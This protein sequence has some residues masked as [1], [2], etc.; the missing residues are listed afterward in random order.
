[1]K[2]LLVDDDQLVLNGLRRALFCSDIQ[3]LTAN[4]GKQALD[5]L[6]HEECDLI[7]SDMMMPNMNG[8]ELLEIVSKKYPWIIRASLSGHA[9]PMITVKGGFYAHQAF[10]KPCDT[11]VLKDEIGRI[12]VMLDQFPDR[13]IQNAIGTI[14]S[15]PVAP[16]IY[17]KVKEMLASNSASLT[18][19]AGVISEDPA[20]S[21]KMIQMANNAIFRGKSEVKNVE[22]AVSRLGSQIVLNV[23]A[24][25]ELYVCQQDKPSK[26]LE[27]LWKQSLKVALV[28]SKLVPEAQ[29]LDAMSIGILHQ[30]GEF[31]RTM[32]LP[33]LM[34]T[35][36]H[37]SEKDGDK[38]YLEKY[39]FHTKSEQLGAYLLHLWGFPLQVIESILDQNDYD[40]I[41]AQPYSLVTAL[42]VAK[43]VVGKEQIPQAMLEQF[44]L[45][46][47]LA[48]IG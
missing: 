10:M 21:A 7:I 8:S 28:M 23:I 41:M 5:I 46:Q 26:A 29:R 48:V 9:D 34:K 47:P 30:V 32:I 24:M 2:I 27:T 44:D 14:T 17:F 3:V 22:A 40:K 37:C 11:A 31:V 12:G 13:L 35:Y 39:L 25:L 20:I 1:M 45:Q 15:L 18:D 33:D 36:L 6:S 19:I 43:R 4:G 38:S 16:K 42:F